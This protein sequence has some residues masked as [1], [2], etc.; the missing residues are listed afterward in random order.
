MINGY[1]RISGKW[2]TRAQLDPL[3]ASISVLTSNL[4]MILAKPV[5]SFKQPNLAS[6]QG[7]KTVVHKTGLLRA[8]LNHVNQPYTIIIGF[9]V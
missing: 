3:L 7:R 4:I 5:N 1:H 8:S 6:S 9:D 2:Y